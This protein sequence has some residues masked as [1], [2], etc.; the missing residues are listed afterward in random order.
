MPVHL[1]GT[2]KIGGG[3]GYVYAH[4]L[5]RTALSAQQ[6]LPDDLHGSVEYYRPTDHGFEARLA[7]RL[8]WLRERLGQ[9][10]PERWITRRARAVL[11]VGMPVG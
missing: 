2:G 4:D 5:P 1:R 8:A 7:T 6:Y 11:A 3:Q 10:P 9:Q